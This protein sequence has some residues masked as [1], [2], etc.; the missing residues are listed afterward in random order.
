MPRIL[1][2]SRQAGDNVVRTR[3]LQRVLQNFGLEADTMRTSDIPTL[4]GSGYAGRKN[5]IIDWQNSGYYQAIIHC[6]NRLSSDTNGSVG[7]YDPY[8]W[9]KP[10]EGVTLPIG[11][12]GAPNKQMWIDGRLPADLGIIAFNDA[13]PLT[14][15][16][17][18]TD[19]ESANPRGRTFGTR[20]VF[21]NGKKAWARVTN[22]IFGSGNNKPG[23]YLWDSGFQSSNCETV[24][25]LDWT[26]IGI[27]PPT[28]N[29]APCAGVRYYN[30]YFLPALSYVGRGSPDNFR[31]T[32]SNGYAGASTFCL[33]LVLWFLEQVGIT[34]TFQMP[35]TYD[36]DHPIPG[37]AS[38]A[39]RTELTQAQIDSI[40]LETMRW[41][42]QKAS[43]WNMPVRCGVTTGVWRSSNYHSGRKSSSIY[44]EQLH[45]LLLQAHSEGI[46]PCCWHDHTYP[47]GRNDGANYTRHTGGN[48]GV[49]ST[50]KD[51]LY[52]Y[53][54]ATGRYEWQEN[55][56]V[57]WNSNE[58]NKSG[59]NVHL[60]NRRQYRMHYEGSRIEMLDLGFSDEHCGTE[61]YLNQAGNEFGNTGFLDFL[62]EETPVR[63]LRVND[64][65]LSQYGLPQ[66]QKGRDFRNLRYKDELELF[67]TAGMDSGMRG[68]WNPGSNA[69]I[70]NA[71]IN[72]WENLGVAEN[73]PNRDR[74]IRAMFL[75]YTADIIMT[76][77]LYQGAIPY[78]HPDFCH[79]ASATAPTSTYNETGNW[80]G[81]IE[82]VQAVYEELC[83]GLLSTWFKPAQSI[84]EIVRW[85]AR[86]QSD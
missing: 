60:N 61:Y 3:N 24:L 75:A 49:G 66:W 35:V 69:D 18:A 44:S 65:T 58:S 11:Y 36:I 71:D 83:F 23:F 20:L 12:F 82:C 25:N 52:A 67:L 79:S 64:S 30:K 70:N 38:A 55:G 7:E 59:T 19:F 14:Y 48:Y 32:Q 57:I 41:L 63:A 16:Q 84:W 74:R 21:N 1:I 45:Q 73:A 22:Y 34:P 81:L 56:A 46:M 86:L 5:R 27:T 62:L 26:E 10:A 72:Q 29:P 78:N 2:L 9:S 43:A 28:G 8:N 13:N 31:V 37:V 77:L 54:S 6:E 80:N 47:N 4:S 40:E 15:Y 17:I 53:N 39:H 76:Q 42:Y 51:A 50:V 68:L 85:R 33:W